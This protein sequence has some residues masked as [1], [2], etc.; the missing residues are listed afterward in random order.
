MDDVDAETAASHV[1]QGTDQPSSAYGDLAKQQEDGYRHDGYVGAAE[2][3]EQLHVF[4][5]RGGVGCGGRETTEGDGIAQGEEY[6]A[7]GAGLQCAPLQGGVLQVV[8]QNQ[9][10]VEA[11]EVVEQAVGVPRGFAQQEAYA[12]QR[13]YVGLEVGQKERHAPQAEEDA[14]LFLA[15]FLHPG[16]EE[17]HVQVEAQ[18]QVHV[19]HVVLLEAELER[20]HGDILQ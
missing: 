20:Y 12:K 13:G 6:E 14:L 16:G 8:T 11:G 18:Q 7:D 2:G 10:A 3:E 19:P 15:G 17:R 4:F 5:R 9:V 1:L